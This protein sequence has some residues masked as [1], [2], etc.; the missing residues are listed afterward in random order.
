MYKIILIAAVYL[1]V[2]PFAQADLRINNFTPLDYSLKITASNHVT[3][4]DISKDF[5]F[6]NKHYFDEAYDIMIDLILKKA[7]S[8]SRPH[9]N[10]SEIIKNIGYNKTSFGLGVSS[11]RV[12]LKVKFRF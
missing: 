8:K 4:S 1:C 2:Q 6:G 7:K 10:N 9:H 5:S 11:H 3:A 12:R